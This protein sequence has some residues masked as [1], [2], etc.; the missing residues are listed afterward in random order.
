MTGSFESFEYDQMYIDAFGVKIV[1]DANN[2]VENKL[3]YSF[4]FR[5]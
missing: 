4:T 5:M 1:H 2:A 3:E